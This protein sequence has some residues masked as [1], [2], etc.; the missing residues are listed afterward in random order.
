[1]SYHNLSFCNTRDG[2]TYD[3][4]NTLTDYID[5]IRDEYCID[6]TLTTDQLEKYRY[7][8]KLLCYDIYGNTE[9]AFIILIINDMCNVKQFNK[10]KLKMLRKTDM[11]NVVK[12]L[13]NANNG[14]IKTYNNTNSQ[15]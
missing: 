11:Q 8:P 12:Y 2:I 4:Y 5:E 3:T 10:K 7:R 1:M 13:Y 9:L 15:T 6:V 14:V